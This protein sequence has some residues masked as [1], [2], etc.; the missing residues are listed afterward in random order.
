LDGRKH[1]FIV[2]S[3]S[4][5]QLNEPKLIRFLVD[6]GASL[7]TVLSYDTLRLGLDCSKLKPSDCSFSTANGRR[8]A[9]QLDD[10]EITLN[11]ND[12]PVGRGTVTFSLKGMPCFAPPSTIDASV[13]A[14]ETYS[15]LGMDILFLFKKWTYTDN[16]LILEDEQM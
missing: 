8:S 6:T 9:Y 1:A 3:I 2:G 11:T 10:V 16:V 7:S 4:C 5:S 13:V 15:L 12:E 14:E